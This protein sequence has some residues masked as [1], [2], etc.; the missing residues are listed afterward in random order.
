M[1]LV[2]LS[3]GSGLIMTASERVGAFQLW[4]LSYPGGEARRITNDANSYRSLSLTADTNTLV[5]VQAERLSSIWT[6]A[7]TD[8]QAQ[9]ARQITPGK[10]DGEL[11][12]AWTLDGRIIY[13]SAAGSNEDLWIMQA[14]GTDKKQLTVRT[15]IPIRR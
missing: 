11:G 7:L 10:F 4:H 12:L 3:D 14:D 2:W 13:Q 15:L 6:V 1:A 9:R 8:G 5:T